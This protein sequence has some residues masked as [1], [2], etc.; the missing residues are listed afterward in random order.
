[1]A[2][3]ILPSEASRTPARWSA[4]HHRL[5]RQLRRHPQLLPKDA[6]LLLAVSGGQDSMAMLGLLRDLQPLHGWTLRLWHGDHGWRAEGSRQAEE[7]AAWARDQGLVLRSERAQPSAS[8]GN[9][10]AW[11]RHW[12]YDCLA[13]QALQLGCRHVLTAH[14]ASDRAETVLL[15]LARG[16]HRRGLASLRASRP[17]SCPPDPRQ[18]DPPPAASPLRLVRPLLL[19]TR[20]ETA[21]ICEQLGL[22]IWHDPS[23]DD[24]QL[25]RNRV[26]SAV[27]PVLEALH[28]G[29]CL[30]ISAQAERLAV[31]LEQPA[32][33]LDLA[34]SALADD[35]DPAGL[36]LARAPLLA[37][38]AAAQRQLL[39]HWLERHTGRGLDSQTLELLLGRLV[40]A[41]GP[42]RLSLADRWQLAWDRT[43]L[44]LIRAVESHG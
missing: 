14:T 2:E 36:T 24:G 41:Q 27:L 4:A 1:M 17:L 31:E 40:P 10:E 7:L 23:N 25:S 21:G 11:G 13:R 8:G 15:N 34:L 16:S 42:G 12:R 29:A 9:R 26:R 35:R 3:P 32:E 28:P 19:F 43:T 20:T 39:L 18:A 22:P 5:H 37:L 30:R 6:S 38:S 33:L 44:K